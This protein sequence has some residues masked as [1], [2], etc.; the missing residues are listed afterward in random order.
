MPWKLWG[1][2]HS[3][4]RHSVNGILIA[5]RTLIACAKCDRHWLQSES[6]YESSPR[7]TMSSPDSLAIFCRDSLTFTNWKAGWSWWVAFVD[8]IRRRIQP[9]TVWA[10]NQLFG[11]MSWLTL[12]CDVTMQIQGCPSAVYLYKLLVFFTDEMQYYCVANKSSSSS[13]HFP[14]HVKWR[15]R[16][17]TFA[18]CWQNRSRQN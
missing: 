4:W 14:H 17:I 5:P 18:I 16:F 8:D 13:I 15:H 2:L 6:R 9:T 1:G 11:L 12:T 10:I 3:A 7:H